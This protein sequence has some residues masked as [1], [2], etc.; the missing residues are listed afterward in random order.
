[1]T[2]GSLRL[3]SAENQITTV[4]PGGDSGGGVKKSKYGGLSMSIITL[5]KLDEQKDLSAPRCP[6]CLC[7]CTVCTVCV[8]VSD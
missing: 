8:C 6:D 5:Y 1:M 7:Q 2:R 3:L 4:K